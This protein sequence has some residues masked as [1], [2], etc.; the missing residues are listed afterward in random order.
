V[1][2]ALLDVVTQ[3]VGADETAI[4]IALT[5]ISRRKA[6]ESA[7][8]EQNRELMRFNRVAVDREMVMIGLK[9]QV[10]ALSIELGRTPPFAL[11]FANAPE[12]GPP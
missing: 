10:N 3:K 6:A 9:R 1:F 7:Q 4:R 5:D 12:G 11:A 8:E 2:Q